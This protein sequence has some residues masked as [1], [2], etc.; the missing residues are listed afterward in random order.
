[1]SLQLTSKAILCISN[2]TAQKSFNR[3]ICHFRSKV[4]IVEHKDKETA[5]NLQQRA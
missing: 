5:L 3:Q 1:M 2:Y 4:I